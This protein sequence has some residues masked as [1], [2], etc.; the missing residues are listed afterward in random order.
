M[1]EHIVAVFDSDRPAAEAVQELERAG[2]PSSAIRQYGRSSGSGSSSGGGFWAWLFGERSSSSGTTRDAYPQDPSYD[3]HIQAG[4]SVL[5][6]T[7]EDDSKIHDAIVI[8]DAHHPI[9]VDETTEDAGD[10]GNGTVVPGLEADGRTSVGPTG[11]DYSSG[12]VIR[13]AETTGAS[14]QGPASR[15]RRYDDAPRP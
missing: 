15:V 7:V 8:L 14:A 6:V 13:P 5:S 12:D 1:R 2:I 11:T 10:E 4:R 9:D 3:R